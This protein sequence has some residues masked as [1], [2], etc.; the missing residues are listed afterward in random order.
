V[1]L[2][3]ADTEEGDYRL[4]WHLNGHGGYRVGN[5]KDLNNDDEWEKFVFVTPYPKYFKSEINSDN[6][7]SRSQSVELPTNNSLPSLTSESTG[8]TSGSGATSAIGSNSGNSGGVGGHVASGVGNGNKTIS[9]NTTGTT[10]AGSISKSS[11][12]NGGTSRTSPP[13]R[14]NAS[15]DVTEESH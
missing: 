10:S 4:S 5:E 11:G 9:S 6:L 14:N 13:G 7:P 3:S 2:A 12:E 8:V 15:D 1:T